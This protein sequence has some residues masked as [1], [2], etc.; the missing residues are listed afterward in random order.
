MVD[1]ASNAVPIRSFEEVCA[2][3][4]EGELKNNA[5]VLFQM[6]EFEND[7]VWHA[8]KIKGDELEA[9]KQALGLE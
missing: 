4:H 5:L 6:P 2:S 1:A 9:G 8:R 7:P 3:C